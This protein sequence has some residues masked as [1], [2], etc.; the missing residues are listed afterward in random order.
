VLP[1]VN[2][3]TAGAP[4]GRAR[5]RTAAPAPVL[6]D[7]PQRAAAEGRSAPAVTRTRASG[8][9]PE[10]PPGE[11][12]LGDADERLGRRLGEAAPDLVAADPRVDEHRHRTQADQREH[13]R[14]EVGVGGTSSAVRM[15]GAGPA[16]PQPGGDRSTR[17]SRSA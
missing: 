11:V 17:A 6:L 4:C 9:Q 14:E 10:H 5:G 8:A 1:L 12:G 13:E 2:T 7:A 16:C 15:P 3:M